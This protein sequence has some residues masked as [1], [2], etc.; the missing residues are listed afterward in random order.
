INDSRSEYIELTDAT[1]AELLVEGSVATHY[2]ALIV[3]KTTIA[4][5]IPHDSPQPGAAARVPTQQLPATLALGLFE[6]RGQLHRRSG[7][8][9][10]P[11]RLLAGYSRQFVP[12]CSATVRYLPNT[13]FDAE[14][15]V[16]LVNIAQVSLGAVDMAPAW[17]RQGL[18]PAVASPSWT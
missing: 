11:I 10:H 1:S 17:T 4:L 14:T 15:P 2:P 12:I 5:A 7:E 13:E 6:V 9:A 16:I 18:V 3:R 8:P